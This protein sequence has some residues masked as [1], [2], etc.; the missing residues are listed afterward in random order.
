[1]TENIKEALKYVVDL[2]AQEKKVIDVAGVPHY[3]TNIHSLKE[4][5][6]KRYYAKNL[7]LNTLDSLIEYYKNDINEINKE[8][9]IVVVD[10]PTTVRVFT[11]DD[12]RKERTELISVRA[13]LPSI[14]FDEFMPS[15]QFNVELQSRFM[16]GQDDDRELVIDYAS[17]LLIEN[18]ADIEDDGVSQITTIRTGVANRDKAKAPNPVEL[19]PYR[20]FLEVKQPSSDFILRLN[21][22][23]K[24]ALFEAD[25]GFWKI[26]AVRLVQEYLTKALGDFDSV[27]VLA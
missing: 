23:A 1:M 2:A 13:E 12:D 3:D 8:R 25:G 7:K 19:T 22:D 17:R 27:F 20:T 26:E 16:A 14:R 10:G 6:P 9:T 4:L 24:L 21:G 18:G 15:D 5:E 11:E